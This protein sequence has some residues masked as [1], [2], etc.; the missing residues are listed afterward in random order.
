VSDGL[1][2]LG[3]P[4]RGTLLWH[5]ILTPVTFFGGLAIYLT[6]HKLGVIEIGGSHL[7]NL[8]RIREYEW[9]VG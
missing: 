1:A 6:A 7:P 8:S 3:Y 5:L 9:N 2:A 4:I